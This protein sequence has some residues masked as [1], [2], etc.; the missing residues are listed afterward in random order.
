M[1]EES[2]VAPEEAEEI[3]KQ[4]HTAL[5]LDSD[6][7]QT[8]FGLQISNDL[9]EVKGRVL[10]PGQG[11]KAAAVTPNEAFRKAA[12]LAIRDSNPNDFGSASDNDFVEAV[13]LLQAVLVHKGAAPADLNNGLLRHAVL[14][15]SLIPEDTPS[16]YE[17]A[18]LIRQDGIDYLSRS[19]KPSILFVFASRHDEH[20]RPIIKST[21]DIELGIPTI[22][23]DSQTLRKGLSLKSERVR[24][25][26]ASGTTSTAQTEAHVPLLFNVA[27]RANAKLGAPNFKFSAPS[28]KL[29]AGSMLV[30]IGISRKAGQPAVAAVVASRDSAFVDYPASIRW[31]EGQQ[32]VRHS[33]FS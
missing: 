1:R 13:R 10:K 17:A 33:P 24:T 16:R 29:F 2:C 3:L 21:C 30:G 32:K 5:G 6:T 14:D 31:Q 4:A 27:L 28:S 22:F 26:A 7:L 15:L 23:I 18:R 25:A 8:S 11:D 12:V 19:E 20:I 9:L